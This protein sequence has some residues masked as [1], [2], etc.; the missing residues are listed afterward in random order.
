MIHLLHNQW[1]NKLMNQ[2]NKQII[3]QPIKQTHKQYNTMQYNTISSEVET[4][5]W[6][7][8]FYFVTRSYRMPEVEAPREHTWLLSNSV[9]DS[10]PT[11]WSRGTAGEPHVESVESI[12]P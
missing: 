7:C 6:R 11:C 8:A 9:H 2:P 1:I 4:N 10:A 12:T 3:N 5:H